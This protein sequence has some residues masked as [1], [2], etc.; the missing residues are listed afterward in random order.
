[1]AVL[2]IFSKEEIISSA[3]R[4]P[5]QE[6]PGVAFSTGIRLEAKNFEWL[7]GAGKKTLSPVK[8]RKV[9]SQRRHCKRKS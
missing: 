3:I 4:R 6:S 1:M 8:E 5:P 2:K 9:I 7:V